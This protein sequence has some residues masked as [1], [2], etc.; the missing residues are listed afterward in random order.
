MTIEVDDNR[1]N[2]EPAETEDWETIQNTAFARCRSMLQSACRGRTS[3]H[4]GSHS[5]K[6]KSQVLLP[7]PSGCTRTGDRH[8]TS[9]CFAL[10]YG[11][12]SS[13][14]C[15]LG[16][17]QLRRAHDRAGLFVKADAAVRRNCECEKPHAFLR[18]S[19][20]AMLRRRPMVGA[21]WS[22]DNLRQEFAGAQLPFR[23]SNG[24]RV[25]AARWLENRCSS[26]LCPCWR[27]Y[28]GTGITSDSRH[29]YSTGC[30][31]QLTVQGAAQR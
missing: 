10:R 6:C 25:R 15:S 5:D 28:Q 18:Y 12:C 22:Y 26:A 23:C 14:T 13:S 7:L 1:L 16:L 4:L 30:S 31:H 8:Q 9:H 27:L 29:D 17:L 21:A 24:C 19:V 20:E 2:L 3:S 11:A